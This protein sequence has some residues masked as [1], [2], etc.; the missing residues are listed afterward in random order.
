MAKE[1]NFNSPVQNVA[2]H[3]INISQSGNILS[4]MQIDELLDL[5][6]FRLDIIEK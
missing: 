3:D 2:G 5:E 4:Q 6:K 1:Q